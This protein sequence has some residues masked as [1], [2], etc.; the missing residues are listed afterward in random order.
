MVHAQFEEVLLC[1]ED[2]M[3]RLFDR[4]KPYFAAWLK[5]HNCDSRNSDATPLYYASLYGFRDLAEHLI[6][7]GPQDVNAWGGRHYSPLAAALRNQHFHV[8]D[9]LRQHGAV[10]ELASYNNRTLLDYGHVDAVKWL[11]EHGA[12]VNLQQKDG[13]TSPLEAIGTLQGHSRILNASI[14]HGKSPLHLASSAHNS[15]K[16]VQLLIQHG[17]DVT[18]RDNTNSTPLHLA[19]SRGGTE[20]M[21]LLI[22]CGADVN[23]Q[24]NENSTPLH[25]VFKVSPS[26]KIVQL[27]TPHGIDVTQA[28]SHWFDFLW[29]TKAEAVEV[30]LRHGADVNAR[31]GHN[32]TPL[33]RASSCGRAESVQLLIRH[34]ADVNARDKSNSTPL[35]LV[36]VQR[37][38]I[39]IARLL[40]EHGADADAEDDMGRTPYE[41][42]TS[43]V[44]SHEISRLILD[45]RNHAIEKGIQ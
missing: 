15:F 26:A 7:K 12:S 22:Q 29:A 31:D 6:I 21:E 30:L 3:Q 34:G 4:S 35:H 9:L 16:T 39:E 27:F 32:W 24:D 18:A 10:V 43:G 2:G 11:L 36:S 44:I 13:R 42:S 20:S 23:C 17:A 1:I 25:R 14:D 5:L 41:L 28:G 40:L 19:S 38:G 8:A 33:H 45:H 37:G